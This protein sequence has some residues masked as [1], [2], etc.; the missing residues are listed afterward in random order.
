MT[1]THID[2]YRMGAVPKPEALMLIGLA[3]SVIYKVNVHRA[4]VVC[5]NALGRRIGD[6]RHECRRHYEATC[7]ATFSIS[8]ALSGSVKQKGVC[9]LS[10]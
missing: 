1:P 4:V 8:E 7:R 6:T 5:Y 10:M 2:C 3:L 9:V